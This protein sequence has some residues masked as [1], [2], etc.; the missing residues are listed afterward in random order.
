MPPPRRFCWAPAVA[1]CVFALVLVVSAASAQGARP[2]EYQVKAAYLYNFGKFID[3]PPSPAAKEGSVKEEPFS[4]C[5]LGRDPFGA[6]LDSTLAGGRINGQGIETRRIAT[7][8][9]ALNCRIVFIGS[10]EENQLKED[11]ALLQGTSV[12]TVSDIAEFSRRGGMIQFVLQDN[13][14]RFEI[15]LAATQNAGLMMSSELLK[16]ASTVRKP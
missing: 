11:L 13:K 7:P 2:A 12:L 4:I 6:I 5:V 1:G 8:H 10:S 15:N 14:V 3:W 9:E 16:V